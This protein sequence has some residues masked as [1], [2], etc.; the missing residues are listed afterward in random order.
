MNFDRV[1]AFPETRNPRHQIP[2]P[3]PRKKQAEPLS[4]DSIP[5]SPR[6]RIAGSPAK[7]AGTSGGAADF[8]LEDLDCLFRAQAQEGST[9]A[10]FRAFGVCG[11]ILRAHKGSTRA[12]G[13]RM[14]TLR[15]CIIISLTIFG[16]RFSQS[17]G[18][19]HGDFGLEGAV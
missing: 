5:L 14:C 17:D 13:P 1:Q 3:K 9:E 18:N 2:S 4:T 12:S 11:L 8:G 15:K 19:L 10:Y 7:T 6:P 16:L